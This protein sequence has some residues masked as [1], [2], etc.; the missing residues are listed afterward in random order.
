MDIVIVGGGTAGWM[1]A[2]AFASLLPSRC[3]VTLVESDE[4][5]TVGVGEATLPQM[6]SFND[7]I[8]IDEAEMMRRTNATFK[9]GIEFV[10]WGFKGSSYIHPF[11]VH[12]RPGAGNDFHH[13]WLRAVENGRAYDIQDFSYAV[14]ASRNERFAFPNPDPRALDAT[15]SYAYHFDASQYAAYLREFAEARG[16][17][18]VE[19]RIDEVVVEGESGR[20]E[21]VRLASGSLVSGDFFIDCSGFRSLILGQELG[22]G[23]EDWSGWLPCDRAFA[24]PSAREGD[25]TPYTRSTALEAGWQWR[26][27]LQHR[28]GNGYVFSSAFIGED[29]AAARLAGNLDGRA[30]GEPRLL[31]FQAG[32][33][34]K[35]WR[36]NCVALGLASGFL[37]PLESTSIY[38][39][40]MGIMHLI[41]LLPVGGPDPR[42]EDEFNRRMDVEYERIRD[43]L[44]LHYHATRRDDSELWRYCAAMAVPDS[45]REKIAMFEHCGHIQQF[46]DGLFTPPSWISV[47]IGQ[48]LRPAHYH[49]VAET[50]PLDR[51]LEDLDALRDEIADQVSAMPKHGAFVSMYC[52]AEMADA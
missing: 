28:T 2:A 36:R 11:G 17:T 13:Q 29:E 24:M 46:K 37:E 1:A 38:L 20:V 52:P 44:I 27:P 25:P 39:I 19:G 47:C 8:G 45:L 6:K 23:W 22:A 7:A 43:F 33:R 10:D 34:T 16:V 35:S 18:R 30:L 15:Y 21:A 32:R 14:V 41:P 49:R 51:H 48:G 4:I 5:G 12:G 9:L 26:I 42:L 40:Q 50:V 3:R 31:R